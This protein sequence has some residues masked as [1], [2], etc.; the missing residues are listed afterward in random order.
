MDYSLLLGIELVSQK[1]K[2]E[3]NRP[4]SVLGAESILN[5]N[6]QSEIILTNKE[7]DE[8]N[9]GNEES[10]DSIASAKKKQEPIKNVHN[11][12]IVKS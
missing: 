3:A 4:Y 12:Q 1:N 6:N 7:S 8:L 9:F 2:E 5:D 10:E 11:H